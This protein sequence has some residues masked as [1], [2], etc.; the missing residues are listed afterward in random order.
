MITGQLFERIFRIED[1]EKGSDGEVLTVAQFQWTGW[2]DHGVPSEGTYSIV[3]QL[4]DI[5]RKEYETKPA[6]PIIV[7]C[8][9]GVGRTGTLIALFNLNLTLE[10]LVQGFINEDRDE[11][12]KSY[13]LSVFGV[14][15]RLREQRWGMVYTNEQ[16]LFIY[17][18]LTELV[19]KAIAREREKRIFQR[20]L[21][22]SLNG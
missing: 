20:C 3:E 12:Q 1:I 21:R 15:R 19:E 18:M 11:K 13:R 6:Q 2:P 5:M 14:V 17:H 22:H 16:Y 10:K 9:A 4:L 7:H 8:S